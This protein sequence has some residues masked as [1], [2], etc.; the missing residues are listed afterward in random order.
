MDSRKTRIIVVS[1]WL[2]KC[3]VDGV[4]IPNS[5]LTSFALSCLRYSQFWS[6]TDLFTTCYCRLVVPVQDN[7]TATSFEQT[8]FSFYDNDKQ[9]SCSYSQTSTCMMALGVLT[10]LLVAR[11]S[12]AS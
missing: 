2:I 5:L 11:L 9:L 8:R 7:R 12:V 4:A 3:H 6:H 10:L 1:S